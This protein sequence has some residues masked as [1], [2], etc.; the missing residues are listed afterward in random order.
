MLLLS[1]CKDDNADPTTYTIAG[2][3]YEDCSMQPKS[4]FKLLLYQKGSYDPF[5]GVTTGGELA[6]ATTDAN[7]YFKFEFKDL[8]GS[9][10]RIQY[11]AGAGYND[12]MINI[13]TKKSLDNLVVYMNPTTNIQVNL[14][15]INPHTS[16]DTL[17]IKDFSSIEGFKL[18]GPFS[19]E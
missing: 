19:S 17:L 5:T 7:G 3:I 12:A 16:I 2:H 13:P 4:N 11:A 10:N 9:E 15:V 18:L 8:K 6:T 14:N 1:A